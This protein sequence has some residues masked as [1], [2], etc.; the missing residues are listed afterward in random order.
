MLLIPVL[1]R[2]GLAACTFQTID[3]EGV[4]AQIYA[5]EAHSDPATALL[6]LHGY[7]GST[8]SWEDLITPQRLC[9]EKNLLIVMAS[10][11]R[12]SWY[13]TPH[14]AARAE[15]LPFTQQL[16]PFIDSVY[17]PKPQWFIGGTSMGGYG[18]IRIATLY[19][20]KFQGVLA[21]ATV[22]N[23]HRY[24]N[25]FGLRSISKTLQ[26][27]D[28]DLKSFT[29]DSLLQNSSLKIPW[30]L[31]LAWGNRDFTRQENEAFYTTYNQRLTIEKVIY[32]GRHT[33]RAVKRVAEELVLQLIESIE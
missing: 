5:P 19:P 11:G 17:A 32:K 29:T 2:P 24:R 28:F 14:K 13:L 31:I 4:S 23:L 30:H 10:T 16:F 3:L 20:Q 21:I 33:Q 7:N 6:L 9:E 25:S 15:Y 22:H 1:A 8:A 27:H 12:A 18:A 26:K